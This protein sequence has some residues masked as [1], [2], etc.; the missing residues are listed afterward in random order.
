MKDVIDKERDHLV[1]Q[2]LMVW[3]IISLLLIGWFYVR[4]LTE[5]P[6]LPVDVNLE[7]VE[8]VVVTPEFVVG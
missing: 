1:I 4:D 7:Q 2:L 8:P 6:Y 3:G 5:I